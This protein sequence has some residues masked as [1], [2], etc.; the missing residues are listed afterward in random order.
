MPSDA[1]SPDCRRTKATGWLLCGN[2]RVKAP[3]WLRWC[4]NDM[5]DGDIERCSHASRKSCI[6]RASQRTSPSGWQLNIVIDA[7]VFDNCVTT[8]I[9]EP[10]LR[11][12]SRL[13]RQ[14][15]RICIVP[16]LDVEPGVLNG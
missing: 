9:K 5:P 11:L 3:S 8:L 2:G 16:L 4:H 1:D 13:K 10:Q 7:L 14:L 6:V 15:D 12:R